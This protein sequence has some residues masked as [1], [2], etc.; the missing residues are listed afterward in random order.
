MSRQIMRLVSGEICRTF[1][2]EIFAVVATCWKLGSQLP[3]LVDHHYFI[4]FLMAIWKLRSIPH[5]I[6]RQT[7]IESLMGF[8]SILIKSLSNQIFCQKI[9]GWNSHRSVG[10]SLFCCWLNTVKHRLSATINHHFHRQ[11]HMFKRWTR[12][13]HFPQRESKTKWSQCLPERCGSRVTEMIHRALFLSESAKWRIF[14]VRFTDCLGEFMI[15][16][17]PKSWGYPFIA[18]NLAGW[19]ISWKVHW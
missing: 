2:D 19:F 15:W 16:R 6:F 5:T 14:D 9:S 18:S 7:H 10:K 11:L 8:F 13:S 17:F 12:A 4:F 1:L 3:L